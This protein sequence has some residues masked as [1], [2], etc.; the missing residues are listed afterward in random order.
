MRTVTAF[1]AAVLAALGLASFGA[2]AQDFPTRAITLIVPWPA[3]G[4]TDAHLRKLAEI[5]SKHLGQPIV[6][7]NR[8]GAGGTAAN[9]T[10]SWRRNSP[11]RARS[12]RCSACAEAPTS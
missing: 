6:V 10:A 8:A 2:A 11:P 3:G 4:S 9:R 1:A 12:H 5:A 7:E